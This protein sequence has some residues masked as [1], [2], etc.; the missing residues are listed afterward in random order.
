VSGLGEFLNI[1]PLDWFGL[2]SA[3]I[4]GGIIGI[5]RQLCGKPVGIRTSALICVGAYTFVVISNTVANGATDNSR[6]IGQVVTG[7]GFLGAGVMMARD[8]NVVGVTS[9]ATIWLQAA[10]GITIGSG[11]YASGVK[12]SVLTV[13]VLVGINRLERTFKF[14]QR[15]VHQQFAQVRNRRR[16]SDSNPFQSD[17]TEDFEQNA[18]EGHQ[19]TSLD[20]ADDE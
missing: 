7:V 5:E 18:E 14:F 10:V 16:K 13:A 9:A 20:Q 4:G 2:L 6:I 17:L 11:Y 19:R 12:L 1:A 3:V 15:G 8:G